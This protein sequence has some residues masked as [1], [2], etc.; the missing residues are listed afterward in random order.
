MFNGSDRHLSANFVYVYTN[1]ISQ[2]GQS[3]LYF[4][5]MLCTMVYM[6]ICPDFI[7]KTKLRVQ[8]IC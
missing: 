5:E 1:D 4:S 8:F 2:F 3:N 6:F 7:I